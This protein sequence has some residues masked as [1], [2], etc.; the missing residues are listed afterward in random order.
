MKP[1]TRLFSS[2]LAQS[3]TAKGVSA[4]EAGRV[5]VA[6]ANIRVPVGAISIQIPPVLMDV[7]LVLVDLALLGAPAAI[8]LF[9]AP[10]VAVL[11][12]AL[13]PRP[14][15]IALG[16]VMGELALVLPQVALVGVDIAI[17][18]SDI[19][20]VALNLMQLLRL[21]FGGRRSRVGGSDGE[22]RYS[23]NRNGG[24]LH[25]IS[26]SSRKL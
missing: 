22:G 14:I 17:I 3:G 26:L 9:G 5:A 4:S 6:L 23:R 19:A 16:A 25:G 10:E 13:F 11:D 21:G 8:P 15:V 18:V 24:E 20:V 1:R 12:G 2:L 7:P